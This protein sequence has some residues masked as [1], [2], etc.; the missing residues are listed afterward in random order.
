MRLFTLMGYETGLTERQAKTMRLGA[1]CG[2]IKAA[3]DVC[4]PLPHA[5]SQMIDQE[6][7]IKHAI[8][9]VRNLT[10]TV[11]SRM[12]AGQRQGGMIN[13]MG[14]EKYR[15]WVPE[16]YHTALLQLSKAG[17]P[18]TVMHF[19]TLAEDFDYCLAG[20][21]RAVPSVTREKLKAAF[22][23]IVDLSEVHTYF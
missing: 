22:D 20:F 23:E 18:I 10:D 7:P 5:L 14:R 16:M 6:Y 21:Q 1:D 13:G 2:G 9:L 15:A 4:K 11:E 19:P 3:K 17:V 12:Q 8:V